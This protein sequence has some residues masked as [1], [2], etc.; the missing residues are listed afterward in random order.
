MRRRRPING[1]MTDE[2]AWHIAVFDAAGELVDQGTWSFA[3]LSHRWLKVAE[4]MLSGGEAAARVAIPVENLDHLE[5]QFTR[6]DGSG[7][8]T[9]FANGQ[10]AASALLLTGANADSDRDVQCLFVES[11]RRAPTA[12]KGAFTAV[13]GIAARPLQAIVIWGNP[14]VSESDYRLLREFSLHVAGAFFF[15]AS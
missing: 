8:L 9:Y 10:L 4:T 14:K 3:R 11:V 13:D 6:S 2:R 12:A 7:I 5:V 1:S 15:G